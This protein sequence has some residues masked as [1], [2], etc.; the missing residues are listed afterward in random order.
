MFY[1]DD[2]AEQLAVVTTPKDRF[3]LWVGYMGRGYI[4]VG[5]APTIEKLRNQVESPFAFHSATAT[6]QIRNLQ[7]NAVV[8]S[9]E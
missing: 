6:F 8:W 9:K 1:E 4:I 7:T 3:G 5:T 2:P